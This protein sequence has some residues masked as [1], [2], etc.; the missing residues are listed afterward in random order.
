[1]RIES[2]YNWPKYIKH[3]RVKVSVTLDHIKSLCWK[4]VGL[5]SLRFVETKWHI[6]SLQCNHMVR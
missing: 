5:G 4:Q 6:M 2:K 3:F 1:M